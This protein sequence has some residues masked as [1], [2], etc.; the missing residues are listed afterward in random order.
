L[1]DQR[2]LRD[3]GVGLG[4]AEGGVRPP[5]EIKSAVGGDASHVQL[6]IKVTAPTAA[7]DKIVRPCAGSPGH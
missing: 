3:E 5:N 4:Y 7:K 2:R 1:P 6:S